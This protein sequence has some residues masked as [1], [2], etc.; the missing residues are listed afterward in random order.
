LKPEEH[1]RELFSQALERV[2]AERGQFLEEACQGGPEVRLQVESLLRAHE[3]AGDFLQRPP[4]L[5]PPG[6]TPVRA[7]LGPGKTIVISEAALTPPMAETKVFSFGDYELLGEIAHGGMG[8]VYKARQIS[9]DRLVALKMILAGQFASETEVK[10]FRAEAEA[11]ANLNHPNIVGI[12]EV[13]VHEGQHYFSMQY[14]EGRSLAQLEA[15]GSSRTGAGKEAAQLL[16][17]VARAVQYAHERGIL[18]RDLKPANILIDAEGEPHVSDFG[19]A[20]RMGADSS[21]T[22]EGAVVGTPSFMAPEQAAGKTKELAAAADIYSLGAI[23]YFLLTGRPPFVAASTLDTL[24]QVLE[25]EVI[26]PRLINP[27]V[28]RDLERICLCCLEKS[29]ETRYAA[30]TTLAED[31]ERFV[32][33]EPVQARPPGL[34]PFLIHWMRRQPALVSRLI[35][36]G[37]CV[38]VAQVKFHYL[39]AVSLAEHARIMSTLGIWALLSVICQC[40]LERERWSKLVPFLWVAVDTVCLTAALWFTEDMPGPLLASFVVLVAMSG[41]WF[42]TPLVGL[43]TSLAV[44]A[45]SF[46]VFDDFIRHHRLEHLNWHILFLV[47]LVLTGGA[48]AY[49]VHCVRALSRFY[50]RRS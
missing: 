31:L 14:I 25:G 23:L 45:Y 34:K 28:A 18:H 36:L 3:R 22:M 47:F 38:T 2:P 21:L 20:R 40:V 9:L 35:G 17:K 30:A 7:G 4:Q 32:R 16:A 5:S 11:A 49:Q 33:D 43:A 6:A 46:L 37:I 1:I 39:P 41:L 10:R 50:D 15:E 24:V 19:V 48:V 13:G 26:V 42:R 27:L 29:P 8:I 12:Y 44:L